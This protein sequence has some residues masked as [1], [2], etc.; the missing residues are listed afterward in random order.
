M[1]FTNRCVLYFHKLFY[2]CKLTLLF[3]TYKITNGESFNLYPA[4]VSIEPVNCCNLRC[5]ECPAG[6][7]SLRRK[8]EVMEWSLFTKTIDELSKSLFSVT[9][10]FQGEPYLHPDFHAMVSYC[11]MKGLFTYTSSN[12]QLITSEVARKTVESGL[13]KIV[14]SVD[15]LTQE[16][17]EK[18]R[19]G[20]SLQKVIEA[21]QHLAYWKKELKSA[22]PVVEAQ[23]IVMKHNECQVDNVKSTVLAWGAD[24]VAFKTAQI[25]FERIEKFVPSQT[26]FSRYVKSENGGWRL[27][28]RSKNRCWRQWAGA[29][30]A[31]NG[32]V[33]P[34]CFDKNGEHVFGNLAEKSFFEIWN[35]EKAN[36][37]RRMVNT[38]RSD[39]L[40]CKN[41]SE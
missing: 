15:G 22:T 17:Y 7:Q 13:D 28:K 10:Y 37:F 34:C 38:N 31:V 21:I 33:Q 27:K 41:C 24:R 16:V 12:A 35:G 1:N 4:S 11:H 25:D 18:Y 19:Q 9:L 26:K 14:I 20:G 3:F 8:K 2:L 36:N 23:F 39:I 6:N 30:V 40:I 32:D 5:P 29:V